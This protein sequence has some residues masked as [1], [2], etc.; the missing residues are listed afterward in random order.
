MPRTGTLRAFGGWMATPRSED[1]AVL[2]AI[3]E[4]S[5]V[6]AIRELLPVTWPARAPAVPGG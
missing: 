2:A 5:R 1:V 4:I 3:S 6:A